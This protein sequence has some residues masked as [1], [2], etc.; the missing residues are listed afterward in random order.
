[1]SQKNSREAKAARR[2]AKASH[3]VSPFGAVN[4]IR[5]IQHRE[6]VTAG[7]AQKVLLSGALTIDGEPVG[8]LRERLTGR[9]ILA[10]WIPGDRVKDIVVVD[11]FTD[12]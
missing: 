7:M 11:P 3:A 4:L 12:A 1:M 8:F 9:K 5:W 10:P 2:A 6:R